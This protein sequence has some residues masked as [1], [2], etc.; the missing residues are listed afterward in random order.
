MAAGRWAMA[1]DAELRVWA[2]VVLEILSGTQG[3][4]Q[5]V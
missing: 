5:S 2:E 3:V 1:W 4:A